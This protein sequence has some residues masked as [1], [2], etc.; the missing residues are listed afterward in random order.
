MDKCVSQG[1]GNNT[2]HPFVNN[3]PFFL[4]SLSGICKSVNSINKSPN[5]QG[6]EN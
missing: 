3:F 1:I 4:I 5:R 6:L 2:T